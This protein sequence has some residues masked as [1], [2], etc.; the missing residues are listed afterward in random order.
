MEDPQYMKDARDV[1]N[2]ECIFFDKARDLLK[3]EV[4]NGR[5]GI[6]HNVLSYEAVK[7]VLIQLKQNYLNEFMDF[8]KEH[9]AGSSQ[10]IDKVSGVLLWDILDQDSDDWGWSKDLDI[11]HNDCKIYS[12]KLN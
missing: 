9:P 6:N 2:M 12:L 8:E 3:K 7:S 1:Y 4:S 10:S 5:W 11:G